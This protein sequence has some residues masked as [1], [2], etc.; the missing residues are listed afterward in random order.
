MW[1]LDH[2]S[3][4]YKKTNSN[5]LTWLWYTMMYLFGEQ[6]NNISVAE[7]VLNELKH[8]HHQMKREKQLFFMTLRTDPMKNKRLLYLFQ[9]DLLPGIHGMI[10]EAKASRDEVILKGSSKQAKLF[11]WI[12]LGVT[13]IGMLFYVLLFALT[14]STDRQQAWGQSF[15]LWLVTEIFL[16]GTLI[17]LIMHVWIPAITMTDVLSIQKKLTETISNYQKNL[18]EE[19]LKQEKATEKKY[20]LL[21]TENN[22]ANSNRYEEKEQ[23]RTFSRVRDGNGGRQQRKSVLGKLLKRNSVEEEENDLMTINENEAKDENIVDG[24]WKPFN[25][26]KYLFLSH[27]ISKLYSDLTIA[28]IILNFHSPYPKQS[29]QYVANLSSSYEQSSSGVSRAFSILL[30]YFLTSLLAMPVSMQDMFVQATTTVMSGYFIL[31]HYQ[32]FQLSPMLVVVPVAA[33]GILLSVRQIMKKHGKEEQERLKKLKLAMIEKENEKNGIDNKMKVLQ[34]EKAGHSLSSSSSLPLKGKHVTRRASVAQGIQTAQAALRS[35]AR[36]TAHSELSK[37]N[38][39]GSEGLSSLFEDKEEEDDDYHLNGFEYENED[40]DYVGF[41]ER[42]ERDEDYPVN[43]YQFDSDSDVDIDKI[44]VSEENNN[45]EQQDRFDFDD[46]DDI[47]YQNLHQP[48][49]QPQPQPMN[50][51][52]NYYNNDYDDY[53]RNN[54]NNFEY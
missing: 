27:R 19:K 34:K 40:D 10:L 26:T 18:E 29:Y 52:Y 51:Y 42:E 7:I 41:D 21:S 5:F 25:A 28:K 38:S 50:Y 44:S 35:V 6:M 45:F 23:E 33:I 31:V 16:V 48:P 22:N 4:V 9:K 14:Q 24:Q 39:S 36:M 30:L 2:S 13:N 37:T 12:Y 54:Y 11:G 17:V 47:V 53:N 1:G 8:L 49:L 46:Q 20:L 15:A 43:D 3:G 32:L